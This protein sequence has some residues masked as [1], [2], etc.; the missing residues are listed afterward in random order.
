MGLPGLRRL[1]HIGVT[2]PDLE[3]AT[4][5]FVDVLGCEYLYSLGPFQ[6]RPDIAL[7]V[8]LSSGY[9]DRLA[10]YRGLRVPEIWEWRDGKLQVRRWTKH[11]YEPCARSE[12]LPELDLDHLASFVALD[13]NQTR[14]VK[15]YRRSLAKPTP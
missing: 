8:V 12:V 13:E 10:V 11:G 3:E 5:F 15:A 6:K 14:L 9:V 7:E 4:S 1:D 2:V